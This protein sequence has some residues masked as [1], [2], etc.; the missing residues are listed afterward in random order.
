MC[1]SELLSSQPPVRSFVCSRQWLQA[2]HITGSF[3]LTCSTLVRRF[4]EIFRACSQCFCVRGTGSAGLFL[5][6]SLILILSE[7]GH[8]DLFA[9]YRFE[10]FW[11]LAFV[12]TARESGVFYIRFPSPGNI[13]I[14][15][16][17]CLP[18]VRKACIFKM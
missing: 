13:H 10:A 5:Q 7:K 8:L 17:I 3:T 11:C 18:P 6:W 12:H 1:R 15:D 14:R 4:V 2:A 16:Q 9:R